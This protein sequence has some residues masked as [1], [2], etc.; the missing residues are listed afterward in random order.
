MDGHVVHS[1]GTQM[2]RTQG[3]AVEPL[4]VDPERS[5][6]AGC[7][8]NCRSRAGGT[9]GARVISHCRPATLSKLDN[10]EDPVRRK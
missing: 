7:R 4:S 10:T 5:H 3:C 8:T 1:R 6:S 9:P 2:E